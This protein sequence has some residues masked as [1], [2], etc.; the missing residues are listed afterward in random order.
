MYSMNNDV[1]DMESILEVLASSCPHVEVTDLGHGRHYI[2][3]GFTYDDGG[4]L[5][6]ILKRGRD[7]GW[8]L[9]DEGHALMWLS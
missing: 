7:G 1:D 2:G 5:R 4:E 6:I 8:V 9:S 3:T